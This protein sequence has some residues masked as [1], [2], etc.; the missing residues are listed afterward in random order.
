MKTESIA[1][2]ES[3]RIGVARHFVEVNGRRLSYLTAGD[4]L[5]AP[6]IL[7][8]HG[9]G[10][11]AGYWL[12]Q[13]RGL[14]ATCRLVAIDL[15]G[16]GQSDAMPAV[17]VEAYADVVG[18]FLHDLGTGPVVVA[19]HSLGGAVAM[20]LAVRQPR[21]VTG[22]ILLATTAKLPSGDVADRW[23][24]YLPG[25]LRKIIFF[26]MAQKLL[27]GPGAPLRAVSLGMH[28]LHCCRPETIL[29]DVRAA[30]A[31]DLTQ[32]AARLT[33]PTLILCGSRDTLT[34]PTLSEQLH[35][36]IPKSRLSIL[37]GAGHMLLLEAPDL[38]NQAMESFV[39]SL[40]A[41][42]R[43]GRG[44]IRRLLDLLTS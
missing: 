36:L 10:V 34:P 26:A 20:A 16:H 30:R 5:R 37:D 4:S 29:T 40:M 11:S 7:L 3:T 1:T 22:L 8:V 21:L 15:P 28:E 13:L 33:V 42:G 17:S 35:R 38:V 19:G 24:A 31:M 43:S 27:F 25:P 14:C 39:R 41:D 18:Q 44:M 12:N 6:S 23:L 9:S 2:N 32:Q